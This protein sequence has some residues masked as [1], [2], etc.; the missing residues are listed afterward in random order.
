[1]LVAT[2]L[3]I[4]FGAIWWQAVLFGLASCA[5]FTLPYG[6]SRPSWWWRL[7]VGAGYGATVWFIFP[8]WYAPLIS[9][10]VFTGGMWLSQKTNG[11]WKL[12]EGATGLAHAA[13]AVMAL[14]KRKKGEK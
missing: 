4:W 13:L 1:M 14:M 5:L 11:P 10:L 3:L 7:L 9:A 12:V 6:D 8:L 2:P